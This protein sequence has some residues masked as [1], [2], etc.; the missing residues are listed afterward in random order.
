MSIL[1][2]VLLIVLALLAC[3]TWVFY[4]FRDKPHL[5]IILLFLFVGLNKVVST[6]IGIPAVL[7]KYIGDILVVYLFTLAIM[8]RLRH[9]KKCFVAIPMAIFV[10][11]LITTII[12]FIANSGSIGAYF[13]CF[14]KIY[15]YF[16][17]FFSCIIFLNRK[18]VEKI[19]KLLYGLF[20]LDVIMSSI[21]YFVQGIKWDF[22]GGI[23]GIQVGGNAENNVFLS[24]MCI[25]A[26]AM[27]FSNK[28]SIFKVVSVLL[29]TIY[30][31][32]LSELKLLYIEL[33]F[34]IALVVL[35][36]KPS[37]KTIGI[38]VAFMGVI[39]VAIQ[40]MGQIY[41]IFKDF[42]SISKMIAYASDDNYGGTGRALNR[43]TSLPYV[44]EN[45]LNTPLQKLFG[46]GLGYAS[47]GT[48][49]YRTYG[50]LCYDWFFDSYYVI[51]NGLLGMA[52]YIM[53]IITNICTCV[54]RMVRN[55]DDRRYYIIG[56]ASSVMIFIYS[57]YD[58]S[59]MNIIAY[60]LFYFY[61]IPYIIYKDKVYEVAKK[62]YENS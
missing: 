54:V 62:K 16:L 57:L 31:A 47:D 52:L 58:N 36:Y 22:N 21:Q 28:I 39:F 40:I 38:F 44:L 33:V 32:T 45:F 9:G 43:L 18:D 14:L 1:I 51:E 4:L 48:P 8:V 13:R 60:L 56:I 49:F 42:F 26:L 20:V 27:F 41:P 37:K 59:M 46:L 30:V 19:F 12:S 61:A 2:G 11:L 17:F 29:G 35:C 24:L 5:I 7:I 23:F 10:L 6:Q 3:M 34:I 55:N 53:F 50:Y 15:R 25:Y